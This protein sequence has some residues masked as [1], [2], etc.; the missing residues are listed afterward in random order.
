MKKKPI[1]TITN[2]IDAVTCIALIYKA[3]ESE[4]LVIT[5]PDTPQE[6]TMATVKT[7]EIAEGLCRG[8]AWAYTIAE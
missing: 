4:W 7:K 3:K 2:K 1:N 6:Q 8:M 5:C